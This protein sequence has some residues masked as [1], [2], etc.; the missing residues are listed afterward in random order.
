MDDPVCE[1]VKTCTEVPQL[2]DYYLEVLDFK[3]YLR[4]K[5]P[6]VTYTVGTGSDAVV[7]NATFVDG[8]GQYFIRVRRSSLGTLPISVYADGKHVEQ[9]PFFLKI[10]PRD[11]MDETLEADADGQCVCASGFTTV[12]SSCVA[13]YLLAVQIVVPL[14]IVLIIAMVLYTRHQRRLAD[15]LWLVPFKA[16]DFGTGEALGKGAF[17]EVLK[18]KMRGTDVAVKKVLPPETDTTGS[19][20]RAGHSGIR[21]WLKRSG[22]TQ[23]SGGASEAMVDRLQRN[24]TARRIGN[25]SSSGNKKID[26]Y[27]TSVGAEDTSLRAIRCVHVQATERERVREKGERGREQ[28][29]EKGKEKE[30]K[31]RDVRRRWQLK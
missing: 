13:T 20:R 22:S 8:L 27:T 31:K 18:A 10:V 7:Q 29:R 19:K 30:K 1:R 17:G 12:G 4:S 5:A 25:T 28:G 21:G 26:A 24:V 23:R 6:V 3:Y 15:K 11:C 16:L 9:S 14:L 2:H